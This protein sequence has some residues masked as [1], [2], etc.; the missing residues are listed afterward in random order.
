V[1]LIDEI[2]AIENL[3]ESI[4]FKTISY[5]EKEK[6]PKQ[7]FDYFIKWAAKTYPEFHQVCTLEQLR[8]LITF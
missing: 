6:F 2:R 5:Q 8:T 1:I 3:A 7:E 4:K